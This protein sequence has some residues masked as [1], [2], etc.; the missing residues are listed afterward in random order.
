VSKV[1]IKVSAKL[2]EDPAIPGV[3]SDVVIGV[4]FGFAIYISIFIFL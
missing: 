2:I 3:I 4:I 1:S